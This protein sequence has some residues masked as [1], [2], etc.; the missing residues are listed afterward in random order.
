MITAPVSSS[1]AWRGH[2]DQMASICDA[3]FGLV[4]SWKVRYD[5]DNNASI[6]PFQWCIIL[7]RCLS[8]WFARKSRGPHLFLQRA[9]I[10]VHLRN[11]TAPH[12][13][14]HWCFGRFIKHT[15]A[16]V[17]L[18]SLPEG[19]LNLLFHTAAS[20]SMFTHVSFSRRQN[21]RCIKL[22]QSEYVARPPGPEDFQH[23]VDEISL[24]LLE[25]T[26]IESGESESKIMK[27]KQWAEQ[28]KLGDNSLRVCRHERS[29]I[30]SIVNMKLLIKAALSTNHL[31][32]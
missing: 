20:R 29:F 24:L 12:L 9:L 27:P 4:N 22:I 25:T 18:P 31:I 14:C 16:S 2:M 26:W 3:Y 21:A 7:A 8:K 17:S 10:T 19:R 23:L 30:W 11:I 1:E 6:Y 13:P 28:L 5:K 32:L 15:A